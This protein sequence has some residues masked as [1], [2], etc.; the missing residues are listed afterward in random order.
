VVVDLG[1][2]DGRAALARATAEPA[3]LVL[4]VD[5]SATAMAEASRRADRARL[6]NVVFLAAG[7]ETLPGTPLAGVADVVTVTFPWGSLLH[8][9][10]GLDEVAMTGIASAIRPG[11]RVEVLTSVVPS[12]GVAGMAGLD[13]CAQPAIAAAW[14]AS[15]L[16]LGAMRPATLADI[17]ETR[18]SWARRLGAGRDAR[19]VWRLTGGRPDAGALLG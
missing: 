13:A 7:A 4:G 5:A 18:S 17:A 6:S 12:D 2:G 3:T 1:T 14:G 19:P 16:C 10:L 11:G 8:G 15:G 9:V